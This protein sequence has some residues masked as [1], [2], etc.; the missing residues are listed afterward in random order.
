MFQLHYPLTAATA[1]SAIAISLASCSANDDDIRP[2]ANGDEI[3]FVANTE[4][5]RAGDITTNNLKSFNVYAYTGNGTS[6]D[7]FMENVEVTKTSSNT[8]TYSPVKYWP[9]NK[10]VDFYAFAPSTW[11]GSATPLAGVPY[12]AV[13][14]TEDIV[15][16]ASPNMTGAA[17]TANAQV[18]FNFRHALSK[19][20]I[21]MSSTNTNLKVN[22]SNV[23]L[24]NLMTKGNFHFPSGSTAD[25]SQAHTIGT[26]T[27]QN[28]PQPYI[29][30]R[31]ESATDIITLTST[32]TDMG[33]TTVP[34]SR[35]L[36][37][38]ELVWQN[39]GNDA[40]TYIAVM[41]SVY[42]ADTGQKLWPNENTLRENVIENSTYGDGLLKFPLST[43]SILE[44]KP[45]YHYVYNLVINSNEDMGAIE[46]ASPTVDTYVDIETTYQ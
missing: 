12:E 25:A 11:L 45:G 20:S 31:S 26:W 15:Y 6:P 28:S 8:W 30:H 29:M 41:C 36:I 9:S 21:K 14:G 39:N 18:L 10:A 38:Q 19:L 42:D 2:S 34:G 3:R 43:S 1:L 16:A 37:P 22:V 27:D 5:S 17:G 13:P 44:W 33:T 32:A 46:F 35:Y 7:I 24:S 4:F 40:D 23:A